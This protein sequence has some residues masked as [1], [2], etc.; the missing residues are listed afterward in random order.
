MIN[1]VAKPRR[2]NEENS[3]DKL[4]MDAPLAIVVIRGVFRAR[5]SHAL[6]WNQ[7]RRNRASPKWS[8]DRARV[9]RA[10]GAWKLA[11][12]FV[13]ACGASGLRCLVDPQDL[14]SLLSF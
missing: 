4:F 8:T 13:G 3:R 12:I 11:S 5:S 7:K 10:A 1:R 6:T 14:A 2:R 9:Q